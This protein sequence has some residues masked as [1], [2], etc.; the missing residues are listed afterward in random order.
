M[1]IGQP[2]AGK[3]TLARVLGSLL[4]LP[5]IHMDHINWQAGWIE[6]SGPEK[7][8]L[9]SDVHT[10]D[11]WIFEGA[12][13]PALERADT[14][15]WLDFPLG[16]RAWRVVRR[17]LTYYGRTRPD[18]PDGC[19]ERFNM[20]FTQYIWNTRNSG[21]DR[22]RDLFDSAPDTKRKYWVRN[23]HQVNELISEL[24]DSKA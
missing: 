10:R 7:D 3:S 2:G 22:I 1:I 19:P 14:L 6:R 5:V 4:Q 16:L 15:I 17:T 21:R 18:L 24:S 20:E 23:K 13:S 12:R 9:C 11:T 8:R